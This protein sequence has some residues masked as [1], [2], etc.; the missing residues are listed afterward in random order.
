MIFIMLNFLR[1]DKHIHE[2]FEILHYDICP[3]SYAQIFKVYR[4]KICKCKKIKTDYLIYQKAC[5]SHNLKEEIGWWKDRGAIS[6][7]EYSYLYK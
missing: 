6:S 7:Q 5:Y 4:A 3:S 2:F 1:K